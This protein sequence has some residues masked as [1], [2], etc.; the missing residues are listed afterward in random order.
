MVREPSKPEG[1]NALQEIKQ[2]AN[3]WYGTQIWG[4]NRRKD[5]AKQSNVE[6]QRNTV[7]QTSNYCLRQ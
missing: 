7:K 2:I 3:G 1:N 5:E 6:K 4:E